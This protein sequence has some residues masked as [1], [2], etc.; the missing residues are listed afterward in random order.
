MDLH[1]H[2]LPGVDDGPATLEESVA[3]A[4]AAAAAG[5]TTIVATPHVELVDVREL[6]DRVAEL[7][8]ALRAAGV[9]LRVEV[10]GE[11][12]PQS[13]G[14][15]DGDDL[16]IIAQGPPGARWL[17]Y[18]VPFDG[19]D[20]GGGPGFAAGAQE[21]RERGYGLLLA[22]PERSRGILPGGLEALDAEVMA[23]AVVAAN[24]GPLAGRETPERHAA[25][26]EILRR[27]TV[28]VIATDAHAPARPWTLAEGRD[29]VLRATGDAALAAGLTG[30]NP[31]ALLESGIPPRPALSARTARG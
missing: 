30:A 16:E 12:K 24:V 25:A 3:Y 11:L 6:P 1:C 9:D 7:R 29:A 18:E 23:G 8:D 17:L 14:D 2:L 20:A 4:A 31:A 13:L 21:L 5:T 19:I 26:V 10:G 28:G 15:L 22:H 27:G